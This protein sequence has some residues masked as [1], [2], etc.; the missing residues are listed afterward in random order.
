[1]LSE[2]ICKLHIKHIQESVPIM[3]ECFF[4]YRIELPFKTWTLMLTGLA[5]DGEQIYFPL[6]FDFARWIKRYDVVSSPFSVITLT[7]P[8]CES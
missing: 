8:L 3:K 2:F 6:S 5:F 7:P 4:R 1:M